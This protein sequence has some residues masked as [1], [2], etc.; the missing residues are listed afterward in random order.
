MVPGGRGAVIS[1]R[2][3]PSGCRARADPNLLRDRHG[4]NL[5]DDRNNE[6]V[7]L[8]GAGADLHHG[9]VGGRTA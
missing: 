5:T 7:D 2:S 9:N 4:V 6:P 3:N 8:N 1:S